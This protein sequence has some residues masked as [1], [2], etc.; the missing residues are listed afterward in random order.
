M[1]MDRIDAT[2]ARAAPVSRGT[3]ARLRS[4]LLRMLREAEL[5]D[6]EGRVLILPITEELRA[7]FSQHALGGLDCIP[8]GR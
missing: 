1:L 3:R 2:D 6:A 5:I 8:G 7:L 4:V